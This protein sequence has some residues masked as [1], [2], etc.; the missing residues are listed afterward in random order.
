VPAPTQVTRG[1][2]HD[3][4]QRQRLDGIA[5][6]AFYQNGADRDGHDEPVHQLTNVAA[7]YSLTAIATDT[8]GAMTISPR[9]R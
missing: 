1:G 5:G 7:G 8:L 2:G 6:V 3:P 9:S 4:R